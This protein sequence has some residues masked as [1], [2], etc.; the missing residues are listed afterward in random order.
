MP[1]YDYRCKSCNS[2]FELLVRGSSTPVCPHC[3]SAELLKC[4]TAPSAPGNSKSIIA[5]ARRQAGKE[6]HF[7]HYSRSERGRVGK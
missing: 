5:S 3:G 7:S 2:Q 1:I 6:G 4:V